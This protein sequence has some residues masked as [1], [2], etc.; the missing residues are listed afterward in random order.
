MLILALSLSVYFWDWDVDAELDPV[1][2]PLLTSTEQIM[3]R[4]NFDT[5]LLLKSGT[6]VLVATSFSGDWFA[7][8]HREIFS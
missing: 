5:Q 3:N 2:N 8:T 7:G 6:L 1:A 4:S